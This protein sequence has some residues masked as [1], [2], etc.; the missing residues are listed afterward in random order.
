MIDSLRSAARCAKALMRGAGQVMF[1][2]SALTGAL[3]IAGIFWG[4]SSCSMPQVAWGA[5]VGLAASAI[6]G[7]IA[8]YPAKDGDDGL[9]GFNGILVGCALPTFM[10][11]TWAMWAA[12]IF[13]AMASAW[14]RQ[15][16]NRLFAPF[17][18]N[19]LTFPFVLLT[20]IA[21]L[22]APGL[23]AFAMPVV[24]SVIYIPDAALDTSPMALATYWLKG[25]S[26]VFLINS[27]ITGLLFLIGLLVC[28]RLA[29]AWAALAS[30]MALALAI[31]FQADPEAIANGLY[32]F[33]PVLTGIALGAT[34]LPPT[35]RT[36][37]WTIAAIAATFLIQA[38]MNTLMLPWSIP[39]LTA[40]FCLATWLFTLPPKNHNNQ[41]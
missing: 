17:G 7:L 24:D 30:A 11:D 40:P 31:L 41:T 28:S 12:L 23:D 38:A 19:S 35:W 15:G 27:P 6:G 14:V 16:L 36:A 2:P 37:L 26:Q 9:W 4:A 32:G 18:A 20:W 34:L 13:L 3:F 25:I 22:A 8:R 1:Q 39:T 29:A 21:L 5:L 10:P 33:S